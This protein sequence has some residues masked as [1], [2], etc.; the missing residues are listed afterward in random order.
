MQIPLVDL[1]KQFAAIKAE[2]LPVVEKVMA[3]AGFIGGPEVAAFEHEFARFCGVDHAVGAANGTDALQVALWA[4]G[5]G[6]GDEVII[7]S[8][9]F[10]ATGEAVRM[11]GATPVFAEIDGATFNIDPADAARKVGAKT[12]AIV[13]VH[14]NGLAADMTLLEELAHSHDLRLIADGAQAHGALHAGLPAAR[15][16]AA[17]TF[18]FYPGKNLGACGD[19]GAITTHDEHL[20]KRCRMI[21]DH[22]RDQKYVHEVQGTNARLDAL[23][24]AILRVKLRHLS[25]WCNARRAHARA[26]SERLAG[27]AAIRVPAISDDDA[28][29]MHLYV[30]RVPQEAR[31]RLI[32]ELLDDGIGAGVHYPVPLHLQPCNR[33]LGYAAGDLPV[34][35]AVARE[36]ISLPMYPELTEAQ[37][38]VVCSAVARLL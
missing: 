35:E 17:T 1:R 30:I 21:V 34:T 13:A 2:L 33:D 27:L 12:K 6:P 24:A 38:E 26:Y 23:Q 29:A 28:H 15:F 19:A 32:A 25:A 11:R 14:L 31:D 10:I 4:S 37:I 5:I 18:S 16:G 8:H 9:T 3:T 22:G 36:I 7:P 20:A